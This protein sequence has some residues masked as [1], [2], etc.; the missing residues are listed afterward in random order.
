MD[1]LIEDT[2]KTKGRVLG[3]MELN[4]HQLPSGVFTPKNGMIKVSY[5]LL[6]LI[7]DK[8]SSPL[9]FFQT[10]QVF[11]KLNKAIYVHTNGFLYMPEFAHI[12]I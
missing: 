1:W 7:I 8:H 10:T 6:M 3:E 4:A 12:H 2:A 5:S 9:Y 11:Y